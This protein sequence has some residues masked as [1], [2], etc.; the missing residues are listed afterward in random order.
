MRSR[1]DIARAIAAIGILAGL[2]AALPGCEGREGAQPPA[3]A[4]AS[5]QSAAPEAQPAVTIDLSESDAGATLDVDRGT[6]LVVR[7]PANPTTGY[8]WALVTAVT[9]VLSEG[10]PIFVQS[11]S[12]GQQVG[13]GGTESW[14]FVAQEPGEQELR[15][16]Y[17]RAGE[18]DAP[19]AKSVTFSIR[20][21]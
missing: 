16:E 17:R 2:V 21:R 6:T 3:N 19:P 5:S 7:L 11:A 8:S 12:A 1:T 10:K 14:S 4:P 18:R 20:V 13:A 15:F 9:N